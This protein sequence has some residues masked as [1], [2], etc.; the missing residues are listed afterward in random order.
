MDLSNLKPAEG[1]IKSRKRIGRGQGSGKGGTSTRGHKGAK[2]R[3]G[4]S[5]KIGFEGGQMPIQRRLPKFGFKPLNR[6]EYKAINLADLQILADTQK[7]SK[8]TPE[9]LLEAG[10]ISRKHLVKILG[11]GTLSAKLE[12][13][14]H[15]FSKT[16]EQAI[17]SAG[18]NAVKI[19]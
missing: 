1:A 19:G 9:L 4:Y 16:A 18:G 11:K 17:I 3:S 5:K 2:S 8:I 6:V 13:E 15:A 7:V 12:V 10:L 14:A